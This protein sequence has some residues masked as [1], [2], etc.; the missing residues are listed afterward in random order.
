MLNKY[1]PADFAI[2]QVAVASNNIKLVIQLT[3][4][5]KMSINERREAPNHDLTQTL[6]KF[7][8]KSITVTKKGKKINRKGLVF[9]TRF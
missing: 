7:E 4:I 1:K 8:Y 2:T 5:T 6:V 9:Y 3:I